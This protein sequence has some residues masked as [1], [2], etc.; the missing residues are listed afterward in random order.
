MLEVKAPVR[1]QQN[2]SSTQNVKFSGIIFFFLALLKEFFIALLSIE[3]AGER[4]PH[5]SATNTYFINQHIHQV[6]FIY[7]DF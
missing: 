1:L 6:M 3:P 7:F 4:I 5:L 2:S